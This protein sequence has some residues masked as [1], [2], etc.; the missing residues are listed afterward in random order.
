LELNVTDTI[1]FSGRIT[2]NGHQATVHSSLFKNHVGF[3]G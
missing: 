3:F 2:A 1:N